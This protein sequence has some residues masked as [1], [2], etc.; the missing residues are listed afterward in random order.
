MVVSLEMGW[1]QLLFENYPVDPETVQAH[2]PTGLDVDTFEGSAY[3]SVVPFTNI[4]VRPKGLPEWAGVPLPELNLRTY[5]T[6]DGVPGVYFFSLDA[7]GLSGVVGARVTQSLP[8]YY[9]RIAM[10][11]SD[12]GIYFRS[13]RRH[14]GARPA[15]YEATYGA[16]GDSFEAPDDPLSQFLLERYRLYTEAPGGH[17]QYTP[18]EHE[19]W[20]VYPAE[21]D[22]EE[23][24]LFTA[25][26]FEHPDSEPVR[27]YCPGVDVVAGKSQSV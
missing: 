19:P 12:D 5:V 17:L 27:Y 9:A 3:L 25:N 4:N 1:R 10:E 7:E 15:E 11:T 22:V 18:V 16:A 14:P 13:T 6:H 2:L 21:A 23:N 26:G 8:Y 20:T 24:T